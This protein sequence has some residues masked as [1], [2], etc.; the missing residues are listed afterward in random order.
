MVIFD[1]KIPKKDPGMWGLK[2]NGEPVCE[3]VW[4]ERK[5]FLGVFKS[6]RPKAFEADQ[7][8]GIESLEVVKVIV[9]EQGT[10]ELLADSWNRD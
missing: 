5:P 4:C 6:V 1:Y 7:F 2:I 8:P 10:P 3:V 9:L